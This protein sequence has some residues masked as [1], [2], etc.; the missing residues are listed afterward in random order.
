MTESGSLSFPDGPRTELEEAISSLIEQSERVL[1]AQGRL[2]ALLRATQAVL[3]QSDL[4]LVLRSIVEAAIE[5]VGAQ[6]GAMGVI[7]PERDALEQ[8][9]YVGLTER[10]GSRHR[11]SARGTRPAGSSDHRSPP[12]SAGP[13]RRTTSGQSASLRIILRWSRSS[14]C[15]CESTVKCSETSI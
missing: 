5:L 14:A 13:H 9:L 6:Y 4:T 3:E 7:N 2:R 12:D 11:P 10:G 15:R 1:R 8:F